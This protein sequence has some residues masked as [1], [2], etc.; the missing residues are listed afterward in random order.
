MLRQLVSRSGAG[1]GAKGAEIIFCPNAG[2][3]PILGAAKCCAN[4]IYYV[5]CSSGSTRKDNLIGAPDFRRLAFGGD[6]LLMAEMELGAPKPYYYQQWQTSGMPQAFRQMPHTVNDRC[7]A[8]I[9]ELYRTIPS[10]A[11]QV[12]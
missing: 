7:L 8:E 9:L 10:P 4:G 11:S 2:Y 12:R 1:V 5:S 3:H 6:E